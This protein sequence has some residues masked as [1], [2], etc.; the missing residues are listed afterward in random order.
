MSCKYINFRTE[1]K[2]SRVSFVTETEEN[3]T[4]P[5]VND[6]SQVGVLVW[7]RNTPELHGMPTLIRVPLHNAKIAKLRNKML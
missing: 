6:P 2:G 1:V 5:Q 7:D 4:A 3:S